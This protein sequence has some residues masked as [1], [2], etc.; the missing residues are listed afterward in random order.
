M[1]STQRSSGDDA[2]CPHCG[3]AGFV[4]MDAPVGHPNFARL[5]PCQCK[6]DE[7]ES[8]WRSVHA[9]LSNLESLDEWTFEHFDPSVPGVRE[10]YEIAVSYAQNP[11]GWL[12][13][14][15]GYGCGKTHLA[16]AIAN[17]VMTHLRMRAV[18]VVVPDLLDHLRGA[19][20]PDQ[21]ETYDAR[22]QTVKNADLLVL[23]D[24]GTENTTPWAREKLY[25]LVNYRYNAR[26]PTIITSNR[27]L[28][29]LDGRVAS[30]IADGRICQG[31]MINAGDYRVRRT[32]LLRD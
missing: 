13:F 8:R 7:Q 12:Y 23:D 3:G 22:F 1:A 5:I 30:R 29:A 21:L 26:R 17:D 20:A 25:Q 10:A 18:F 14:V 15:G 16:A 31:V 11:D 19:Y 24:L 27:D 2:S 28:S 32:K 4:R 6:L 9:E